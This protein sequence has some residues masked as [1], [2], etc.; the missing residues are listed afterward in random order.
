MFD[1]IAGQA[2]RGWRL[3]VR[4]ATSPGTQ[5]TA[6]RYALQV[7]AAATAVVVR[8]AAG[9]VEEKIEE[10]QDQGSLSPTAA[11]VVTGV[12]RA[13]STGVS[14]TAAVVGNAA[15]TVIGGDELVRL[16]EAVRDAARDAARDSDRALPDLESTAE[17]AHA[18]LKNTAD[19]QHKGQLEGKLASGVTSMREGT[20]PEDQAQQPAQEAQ[21][22]TG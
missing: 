11:A 2:A 4:V 12:V 3:A 17:D 5:A 14:V 10:L 6:K 18:D 1:Q 9:L 15:A 16:I 22:D 19:D 8:K 20:R 21:S 7:G 13:T